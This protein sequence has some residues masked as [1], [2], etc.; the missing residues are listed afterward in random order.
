MKINGIISLII[1]RLIFSEDFY[2]YLQD[3]IDKNIIHTHDKNFRYYYF[4]T[5]IT[6]SGIVR[7]N[8]KFLQYCILWRFDILEYES[9][10][11]SYSIYNKNIKDFNEKMMNNKCVFFISHNIS[12]SRTKY[13]AFR[14]EFY[15]QHYININFTA[16]IDLAFEEYNLYNKEPLDIF[17]LCFNNS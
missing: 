14:T 13:V 4:Y 5:E 7:F 6:K 10:I 2:Y 8:L 15:E 16:R 12:S 17:N 9:S 11:K 3:G 1:F